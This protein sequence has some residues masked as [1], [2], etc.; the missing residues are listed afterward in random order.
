M[1]LAPRYATSSD[2]TRIGSVRAGSG[3]AVL[4]VH[5][6]ICDRT[7]WEPLL[8]RLSARY[9]VH[10]LDRRGR[11]LSGDGARYALSLERDDALAVVAAIG[12]PV[13]VIGH[14]VG[15]LCALEA[16]LGSSAV[17]GLVLYGPP[18]ATEGLAVP[19]PF[20]EELDGLIARG[21][22]DRAVASVMESLVGLSSAEVAML[23]EDDA[24]WRPMVDTVALL[25]RE[26]RAVAGFR[27][28]PD[29]YGRLRQPV[30]LLEGEHA[31][32]QLLDGARL[33]ATVL[34]CARLAILP[35]AGHEGVTTH[36]EEVSEVILEFLD[37]L[38]PP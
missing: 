23:R 24:V 10:A 16:A 2:G 22:R 38:G 9:A 33:A 1:R 35:G 8:P 19:E 25:P 17:R 14:S 21:D 26:L 36:A 37:E 30:L 28:N 34:P 32:A 6:G 15:T 5:G 3:P 7:Y 27:F 31:P 11:G 18:L 12:E 29:R 13:V 20:L 4:A